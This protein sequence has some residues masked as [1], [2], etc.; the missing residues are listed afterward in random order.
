MK[1]RPNPYALT[2]A[3]LLFA[4]P[5][6][7]EDAPKLDQRTMVGAWQGTMVVV[8]GETTTVMPVTFT[9]QKDGN[10]KLESPHQKSE[11]Q[12][13]TV[14]S[15]KSEILFKKADGKVDSVMRRAKVSRGGPGGKILSV[16][17]DLEPEDASGKPAGL[18]VKVYLARNP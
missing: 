12:K 7:A 6:L 3:A 9:F 2:L 4:M 15:A 10:V 5:A 13:Y 8:M 11:T 14:D 18:D 17:A 16:V 1:I